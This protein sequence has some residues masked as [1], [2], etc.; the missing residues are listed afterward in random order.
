MRGEYALGK[1]LKSRYVEE[2][3]LLNATYIL[4]E[5]SEV[6]ILSTSEYVLLNK[7]ICMLKSVVQSTGW[8]LFLVILLTSEWGLRNVLRLAGTI[9]INFP[10]PRLEM[11]FSNIDIRPVRYVH[12]VI[13]SSYCTICFHLPF[14]SQN[15]ST[16]GVL[17][18]TVH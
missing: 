14:G 2:Y 11:L 10:C 15:R 13:R 17:T 12:W 16:F 6:F 5:V 18:M 4:K 7:Y 9:K 1:F 3:K 8:K